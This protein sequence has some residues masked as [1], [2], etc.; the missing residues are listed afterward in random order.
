MERRSRNKIQGEL[1]AIRN[2]PLDEAEE[3]EGADR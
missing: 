1:T 3:A 2:L